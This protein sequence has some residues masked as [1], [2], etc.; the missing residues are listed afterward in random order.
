MLTKETISLPL[1][2]TKR[3][4]GITIDL[5][6]FYFYLL[7]DLLSQ[8]YDSKRRPDKKMEFPSV[9]N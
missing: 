4:R 1:L 8:E 6:N 7:C 9:G 2:L 5:R 3:K